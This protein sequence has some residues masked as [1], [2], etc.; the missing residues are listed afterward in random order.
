[1]GSKGASFSDIT[2]QATK[3]IEERY[4]S[5]KRVTED[6][7]RTHYKRHQLVPGLAEASIDYERGLVRIRNRVLKLR[8]WLDT[9]NILRALAFHNIIQKPEILGPDEFIKMTKLA[10]Q[11][12]GSGSEDEF[13]EYL[14]G[15]IKLGPPKEATGALAPPDARSS[16]EP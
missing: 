12:K 7:I 1:M 6:S 16:K 5:S 4:P 13:A 2:V 11:M 3:I 9:I 8:S 10:M 15:L 14:A